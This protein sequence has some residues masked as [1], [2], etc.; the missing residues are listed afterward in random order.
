MRVFFFYREKRQPERQT[1]A[2]RYERTNR[3]TGRQPGMHANKQIMTQKSKQYIEKK[4]EQ[5]GNQKCV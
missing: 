5:V 3:Q 1:K 2:G 4:S